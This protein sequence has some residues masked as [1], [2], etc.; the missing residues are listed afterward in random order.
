MLR[1]TS[2]DLIA[3][4]VTNEPEQVKQTSSY[5]YRNLQRRWVIA[6]DIA[7]NDSKAVSWRLFANLL[8]TGV[9]SVQPAEDTLNV[10]LYFRITNAK[11]ASANRYHYQKLLDHA[12]DCVPGNR[13]QVHSGCEL[14]QLFLQRVVKSLPKDISDSLVD[15]YV[16]QFTFK[17]SADFSLETGLKCLLCKLSIASLAVRCQNVSHYYSLSMYRLSPQQNPNFKNNNR[18]C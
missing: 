16:A 3:R 10:C 6:I 4:H 15:A 13:F 8:L 14:C 5:V 11:I 9:D 7:I 18:N 17:E 2:C 12:L 1:S